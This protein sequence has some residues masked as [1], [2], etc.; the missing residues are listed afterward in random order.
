MPDFIT[1]ADDIVPRAGGRTLTATSVPSIDDV[2]RIA[3]SAE[4]ELLGTMA[5]VGIPTSYVA[6]SRGELTIRSWVAD[7]VAGVFRTANA[8][9]AGDGDN[10]DGLIQIERWEKRLNQIVS[11]PD[12]F[13][14]ML[15]TDGTAPASTVRIGSHATDTTLDIPSA[16]LEPQ[17]TFAKGGSNF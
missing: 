9:A 5:S 17:F 7:Y 3:E 8:A 4:A 1:V 13:G 12:R 6:G 16:D 14:G 11:D 2:E 15:T 10:D